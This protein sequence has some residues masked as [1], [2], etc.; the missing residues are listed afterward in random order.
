MTTKESVLS[1]LQTHGDYLS[2]EEMSRA[3]GLSRMAV[4]K[5]IHA[6]QAEG[7][8]ISAVPHRGYRLDSLPD[9]MTQTSVLAALGNHP[10]QSLVTV[11]DTVDSTNTLAK[12]MAADGAPEGTVII[13]NEQTAGRGRR[14]RQFSSPA[15][16]GIYLSVVLRPHCSPEQLLHMTA[17]VA[18]AA[19]QAVEDAVG[20]RPQIKWTNDLV[21][22]TQKLSG[23]LTELTLEAESG[24]VSSLIAGI[25]I[26][27]GQRPEDFP[28]ELREIA[29]SLHQLTGEKIDRSR[30]CACLICRLYE[31]SKTWKSQKADWLKRYAADCMTIGKDISVVRGDTVRRAHADGI[32]DNAAL[33]VT[34]DNGKTEAVSSGEVSVRGM[35]GYL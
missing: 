3:L 8:V 34:Y 12:R 13:S 9:R 26:N 17:V 27:C 31:V 2:G 21:Y 30:L 14:G 22:G 20:L 6:L 5:A 29:T 18:E 10:W 28:P 1:L 23:T 15:N 32:D 24:L 4:N 33:L 35:Y 25:G 7:C 16:M 11:L 19:C